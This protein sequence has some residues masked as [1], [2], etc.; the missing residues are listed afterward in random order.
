VQ[1]RLRHNMRPNFCNGYEVFFRVLDS[2]AGY[3]E[4]VRWNGPVGGFTSLKKLVGKPYGV[5]NGDIIEASVVG[6]VIT[7]YLNGIE[8][9]SVV[10]DKIKSGAPGIGFNFGVADTN[11]D[12]GVTHFEV[13]TSD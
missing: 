6:D 3:A 8:M 7:G 4:I 13:H 5:K 12:H 11:A 10:D 1:I 2:D 9:I